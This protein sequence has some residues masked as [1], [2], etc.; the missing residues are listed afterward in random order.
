MIELRPFQK[1]AL[2]A[3]E[4][5][6]QNSHHVLVI[7]PTGSGK[8]LIYE[9]A[10]KISSRRT[11]LITPLVALARQ[12]FA[13]LKKAEIQVSLGAGGSGQGPPD[14]ESGAWII[15]PEIL[16][17]PAGQTALHHWKPN[18]LV[19]DEC[20]CL[21]EWGESFRPA[22]SL[23][24]DLLQTYSI[25]RSLWL[26]AT[27]PHEARLQLKQLIGNPVVEIGSF[28]LPQSLKLF[29][30][31]VS[32]ETRTTALLDWIQ[33]VSGTGIIFVQTRETTQR[34]ARLIE[35]LGKKVITY[36]GGMSSEERK[37]SEKLILEKYPDVI[38]ATSAFG[39]G[40]DY[41]HL[42]FVIL[43]QPPPSILSLVQTIGRVGRSGSKEGTAVVFWDSED[44]KL[45]EWT[46]GSS[47]RRKKEF[48][49]L[50]QFLN[51]TQCR[52]AAL[53]TY[54]DRTFTLPFCNL[55]DYCITSAK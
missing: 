18:F 5:P 10:S 48:I 22:F 35:A 42:E 20:H 53:K 34:I 33:L 13:Q 43:W 30:Q 51:S 7:A 17:F 23:I 25:Q 55:C 4:C 46:V 2:N 28:D 54:F 21:W 32:W 15:S 11:L 19:V 1:K 49:D 41:S 16:Q 26:T 3:L 47:V 45:L 27:L 44:F 12:Q 50:I 24:P 8:S 38:V 52:R 36:H 37:N 9:K 31:K 6:S 29:I 14:T 39:M 40:M